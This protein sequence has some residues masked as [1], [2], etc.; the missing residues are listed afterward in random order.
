MVPGKTRALKLSFKAWIFGSELMALMEFC[1]LLSCS[2]ISCIAGVSSVVFVDFII[3]LMGAPQKFWSAVSSVSK[4][5]DPL[6]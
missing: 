1:C 5:R 4:V 6:I 2:F 3:N